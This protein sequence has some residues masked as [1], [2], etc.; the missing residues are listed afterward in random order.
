MKR[1]GKHEGVGN[2][3]VE[4]API[5]EIGP[6]DILVR[7]VRS[8]ISRGS[9]IG[10]RYL[11]HEEIDPAIMGY[12]VAGYVTAVGTDV[13]EYA[14]GDR[15]GISAPHAEYVTGNVDRDEGSW[16]TP[17][18]DSVS[19]DA[20]TFHPLAVGGITWAKVANA[21][22]HETVVILGMGLVG[23]L[24]LQ[25]VRTY[26]PACLIAV[27]GLEKRRALAR[28]LGADIVIDA[29]TEDT[30]ARV[31]ELTDGKGAHLVID[32]VGGKAG[33]KSFT[34]ALDCCRPLGRIHLIALYHGESLP[35]D[36]GKIQTRLLIGG[37]HIDEPRK[38]LTDRA[39]AMIASG[40]LQVEPMI[41]HHFPYWQAKEAY[42]LLYHNPGDAFGVILDWPE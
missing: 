19:Y 21:Q 37:Y 40:E 10:R 17:I 7:N 25:A 31:S 28:Q 22:P 6:R 20:A 2:V 29:S 33:V 16:I 14:V 27:D 38:P 26:N 8:L 36:A 24:V 15:V 23:N 12:S 42:D 1:V 18:P 3:I 5:P 39:M 41:T 32:C 11:Y 34:Q 4:D 13:T 35:L 30:V 9:E